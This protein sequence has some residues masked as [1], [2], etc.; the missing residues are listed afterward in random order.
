M[1]SYKIY[2]CKT[3]VI[4]AAW[5]SQH[6]AA[7]FSTFDLL[8]KVK[9]LRTRTAVYFLVVHI[10]TCSYLGTSFLLM[11]VD[12]PVHNKNTNIISIFILNGRTDLRYSTINWACDILKFFYL[13]IYASSKTYKMFK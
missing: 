7:M 11:V 8:Q 6:A 9:K 5:S 10:I 4:I 13:I 2:W 3:L 12:P 1:F